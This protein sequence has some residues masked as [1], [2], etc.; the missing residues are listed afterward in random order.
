MFCVWSVCAAQIQFA[1]DL[2]ELHAGIDK[3]VLPPVYGG[4]GPAHDQAALFQH[5]IVDKKPFL[6]Y[7]GATNHHAPAGKS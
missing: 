1:Y 6:P 4:T 2:K 7:P 3:G 5:F